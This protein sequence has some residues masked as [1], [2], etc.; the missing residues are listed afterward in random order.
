VLTPAAVEQL[1]E[2]RDYIASDAPETA[3]DVIRRLLESCYALE[4]LPNRYPRRRSRKVPGTIRQ[5]PALQSYRVLY[6]VSDDSL[7]V[8]ILGVQH[9]S[10]NRW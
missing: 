8:I 1:A 6:S 2:I 3:A 9:G 4:I 10:R 5:M 7:T